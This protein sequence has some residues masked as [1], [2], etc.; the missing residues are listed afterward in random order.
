MLT[1]FRPLL[2]EA[3]A[4]CPMG[5]FPHVLVKQTIEQ[6]GGHPSPTA[7]EGAAGAGGAAMRQEVVG[8]E[9]EVEVE[10]EVG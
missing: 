1:L 7:W 4:G 5:P 10:V 2:C 6:D 3:Q 8:A 9:A